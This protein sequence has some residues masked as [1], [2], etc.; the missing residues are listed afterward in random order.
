MHK[1]QM[2]MVE[3]SRE[4]S[5]GLIAE[6]AKHQGVDFRMTVEG[7]PGKPQLNELIVKNP[8]EH[9]ELFKVSIS[10]SDP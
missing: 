2:H 10:D 1:S 9:E 7:V 4:A 5:R 8:F 3:Y 6:K